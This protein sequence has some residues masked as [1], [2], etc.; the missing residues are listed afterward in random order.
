MLT[1]LER[2][3]VDRGTNVLPP[4][5]RPVCRV[6]GTTSAIVRNGECGSKVGQ[7]S[8]I[9]SQPEPQLSPELQLSSDTP[10][11]TINYMHVCIHPCP[12][13]LQVADALV[14]MWSPNRTPTLET[15]TTLE[16]LRQDIMRSLAAATAACYCKTD[17]GCTRDH[18]TSPHRLALSSTSTVLF[19]FVQGLHTLLLCT[20]SAG[21]IAL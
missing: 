21:C 19:V 5:R 6:R 7:G 1:A 10:P 14:I 18:P 15:S 8:S 12:S 11:S 20:A 13:S 2:L 9:S 3:D 17:C 16:G 4:F